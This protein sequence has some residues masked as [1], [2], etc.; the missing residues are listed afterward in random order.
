MK[1]Y[2][3][4][5]LITAIISGIFFHIVGS[6]SMPWWPD[7]V[8]MGIVSGAVAVVLVWK[9]RTDREMNRRLWIA[10]KALARRLSS[11]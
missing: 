2:V 4:T 7:T 3:K 8:S 9:A 6:E 5:F 10:L 11:H 1:S